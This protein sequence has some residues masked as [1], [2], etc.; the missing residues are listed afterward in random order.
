MTVYSEKLRHYFRNRSQPG[1]VLLAARCPTACMPSVPPPF[2]SYLGTNLDVLRIVELRPSDW[3]LCWVLSCL[4]LARE[5]CV[6]SN[7]R[8]TLWLCLGDLPGNLDSTQVTLQTR[9]YPCQSR[10][11]PTSRSFSPVRLRRRTC[12]GYRPSGICR[13]IGEGESCC[14]VQM[15]FPELSPD[16]HMSSGTF[17]TGVQCF[18][19]SYW[20]MTQRIY[21][22]QYQ[23]WHEVSVVAAKSV[24]KVYI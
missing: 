14:H 18:G 3:I 10:S 17:W 1:S 2:S 4:L 7:V 12:H 5:I 11:Y 8:R 6:Y 9:P 13:K 16:L 21:A 23:I 22:P 20:R 24:C 19:I 15:T